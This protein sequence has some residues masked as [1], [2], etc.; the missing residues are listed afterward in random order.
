MSEK[1]YRWAWELFVG[2]LFIG[3]GLGQ[4]FGET[5]VG[6]LLGMGI[7]FILTAI[8]RIEEERPRV[9]I[10]SSPTL[11][12]IPLIIMG[13]VF[14]V[15]GLEIFGVINIDMRVLLGLFLTVVGMAIVFMGIVIMARRRY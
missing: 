2:S 8:I 12:S 5:G 13:L 14:I 15:T 1:R 10:R 3:I 11:V 7:G 4:I 6:A 9:V